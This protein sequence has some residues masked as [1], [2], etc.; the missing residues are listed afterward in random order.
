MR[1]R[2][3]SIAL[4]AL[5]T[6]SGCSGGNGIPRPE[7]TPGWD[8]VTAYV[9]AIKRET[10]AVAKLADSNPREASAQADAALE[11]FQDTAD[12]GQYKETVAEIKTILKAMAS[13]KGKA[14]GL[15]ELAEKLPGDVPGLSGKK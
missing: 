10:L 8:P 1:S 14:A 2:F 15:K 13:G 5:V 11:N 6:L 9:S 3:F 4:L 7:D 12:T